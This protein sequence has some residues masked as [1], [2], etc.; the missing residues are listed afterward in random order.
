[1]KTTAM[2]AITCVLGCLGLVASSTQKPMRETTS[3][4]LFSPPPSTLA[5][6][7]DGVT[8]VALGTISASRG[9]SF[10]LAGGHD[11][12]AT[13][14]SVAVSEVFGGRNVTP[15]SS[16]TV[17]SL[18]GELDRGTYIERNIVPGVKPLTVGHK[19]ILFLNWDST[20]SSY[21]LAYGPSAVLEDDNG[22]AV[23]HGDTGPLKSI[24]GRAWAEA[25]RAVAE[26]HLP[27]QRP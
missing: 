27:R 22:H 8:A 1:M 6:M 26:R 17:I 9:T 25:V 24:H 16:I 15:G 18:G 12:V 3:D 23:A 20:H 14:Y 19:Y 2:I 7:I 13:E 5:E 10:T 4:A 11:A 21:V